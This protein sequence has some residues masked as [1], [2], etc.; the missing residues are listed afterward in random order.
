[1][2]EKA[3]I[4]VENQLTY[5]EVHAAIASRFTPPNVANFL[6]SVQRAGL[7]IR[8]F[9]DV[10]HAG[11]LGDAIPAAWRKLGNADQGQIREYYLAS[12]EKVE[13]ALRAKYL[14]LYAYY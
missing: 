5:G 4:A 7:R 13:P 9:E 2:Y 11:L 10:V 8:S 6:Q 14:K 1:M 3:L 12:V